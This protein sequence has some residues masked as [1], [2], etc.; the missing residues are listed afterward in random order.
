[1]GPGPP[2]APP[3]FPQGARG[4]GQLLPELRARAPS[5]F[6][7][8]HEPFVGGGAMAFE[9]LSHDPSA[10]CALSDLNS[11]LVIAYVAVRDRLEDLLESLR[12]HATAYAQDP[13]AYYYATRASSP[14]SMVEKASRLLFLNRTCFNG[15]YRVNSRGRFNVPM[16]GYENPNI[17]NEGTLRAAS[18]ALGASG[19]TIECADFGSVLRN[20]ERGDFVYFDPPYQPVSRTAAF[21]G[22]TSACFGEA[23]LRR[24]AGACDELA[25]RGCH[26]LVSNSDTGEVRSAFGGWAAD[27]VGAQRRINSDGARRS[28]HVELLIRNY[29]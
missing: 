22:Y 19:V 18:R 12:G 17:V 21:T 3:A 10:R 16:G 14:R 11:D 2:G 29:G 20:A 15:L 27:E 13:K 24:L 9:V 26:V 8:Y 25:E 1:G 23:D 7:A 4:K 6:G 5:R 28:G